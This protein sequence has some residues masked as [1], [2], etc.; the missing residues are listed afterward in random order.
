[1]PLACQNILNFANLTIFWVQLPLA[2]ST[3]PVQHHVQPDHEGRRLRRTTEGVTS[4]S[5]DSEDSG[6]D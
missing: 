1:M 3:L 2:N 5:A 6:A 4:G